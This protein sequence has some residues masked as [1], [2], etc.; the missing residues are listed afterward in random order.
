[1]EL[2]PSQPLLFSAPVAR[3]IQEP[4]RLEATRRIPRPRQNPRDEAETWIRDNPRGFAAFERF[5]LEAMG[6]GHPCGINLLRERVR[7]EA[8][9]VWGGEFK[10]DNRLSPYVARALIEKHPALERVLVCRKTKW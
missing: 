1:M 10:F 6:S 2:I 7:W 4:R 3:A 8:S 9:F 5:A